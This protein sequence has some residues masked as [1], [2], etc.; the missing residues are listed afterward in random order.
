MLID[1]I[2]KIQNGDNDTTLKLIVK[3]DPLLK[4]YAHSLYYEDAYYDLL[5]DFIELLTNLHIDRL[6]YKE[7]GR[8]ISYI[9][10]SIRNNYI[11]Q[12]IKLKKLK[13]FIT[14]SY[15]SENE[16]YFLEALT[17][18][19]DTYINLDYDLFKEI[20]TYR[21]FLVIKM[22]FYEGYSVKETANKNGITRQAVN[23]MKNSALNKLKLIYVDKH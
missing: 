22:I 1:D 21:E 4:K 12:L 19:N 17:A 10:T 2:I 7:D 23:Q 16:Q 18:T 14:F 13:N 15:L 11:K 6:Q 8:M 20:L 9:T 3:F 5:V